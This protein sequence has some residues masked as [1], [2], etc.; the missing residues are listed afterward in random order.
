MMFDDIIDQVSIKAVLEKR[1][2][3]KVT[4]SAKSKEIINFE[5]N[6]GHLFTIF[7]ENPFLRQIFYYFVHNVTKKRTHQILDVNKIVADFIGHEKNIEKTLQDFPLEIEICPQCENKNITKKRFRGRQRYV[8]NSCKY[9]FNN[10]KL[11]SSISELESFDMHEFLNDLVTAKVLAKGYHMTCYHCRDVT[12]YPDEED[13]KDNI[14]C[15]K[16]NGLKDVITIYTLVESLGN[17]KELDSI[18]LEWYVIR[19]IFE[20]CDNIISILP[21]YNIIGENVTTEVDL[22][23]LT[24]NNQLISIDCKAKIFSSSLSKNDMNNNI[25]DWTRFSDSTL[26]VTNGEISENC[27]KFWSDKLNV[28]KFIDGKNLEK[29]NDSIANM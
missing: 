27:E 14:L 12:S 21:T 11:K 7:F 22:L 3:Y 29:L 8:C 13:A 20:K 15:S 10:P 1:G 2:N 4:K 23:V 28:I 5:K 18:W 17:I 19:L 26:I 25:L 24:K 16:C 6:W 9:D